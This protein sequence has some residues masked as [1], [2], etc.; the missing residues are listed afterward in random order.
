QQFGSIENI[1]AHLDE[2]KPAKAQATLREHAEQ[3]RQSKHLAT[4]ICD[5]PVRLDLAACRVDGLDRDRLV[6]IFRALE[7]HRLLNKLPGPAA[8]AE[9]PPTAPPVADP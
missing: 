8:P 6:A 3:A 9:A 2:V 1:L 7:F 4:I 5:V